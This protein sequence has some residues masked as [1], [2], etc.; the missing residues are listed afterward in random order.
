MASAIAR[1]L[2]SRRIHSRARASRGSWC[3]RCAL[4]AALV[5]AVDHGE[6]AAFELHLDGEGELGVAG[7]DQSRAAF[8]GLGLGHEGKLVAVPD[9]GVDA[10]GRDAERVEP[11]ERVLLGL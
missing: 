9:A 6:P 2:R 10:A 8:V 11:V 3:G 4:L 7:V 5:V 1:W